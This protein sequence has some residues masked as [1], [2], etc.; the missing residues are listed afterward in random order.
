MFLQQLAN[1][2]VI[3]AIYALTAIGYSMVYGLIRMMN[4]AHVDILMFGTYLTLILY[5]SGISFIVA[6]PLGIITGM[7]VA[8]TIAAVAYIPL[9]ERPRNALVLTSV[10]ASLVLVTIA[11]L[12]FGPNVRPFPKPAI[13]PNGIHTFSNVTIN[14]MQIIILVVS[15]VSMILLAVFVKKTRIGIAM[16]ATSANMI[17]ARLVGIPVKLILYITFAIGSM[18]AVIAGVLVGIYY[19]AVW[20]EMGFRLGFAA[21]SAAVLGGIGSMPG[22]M[23]GGFIIGLA[24]ALGAAYISSGFRDAIGFTVLIIVLLFRPWGIMAQPET[25][26]I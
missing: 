2:I 25:E 6:L 20:P 14:D 11:Q 5:L 19:N 10:S 4:F 16:R 3:G 7:L 17:A 1:G 9:L 15:V 12:I 23:I 24:E 8:I 26:N 22:A 18:M 21:F 13:L